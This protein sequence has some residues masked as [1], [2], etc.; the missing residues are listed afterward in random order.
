MHRNTIQIT[1]IL[2]VR[3]LFVLL[4]VYAAV[5]K[6]LDFETFKIQIGDTVLLRAYASGIA[7]SLIILQLLTVVLLLFERTRR[8]GLY[9]S[10]ILMS[11]F[12]VYILI[13][14]IFSKSIPCACS[15]IIPAMGW[16]AHLF[17]NTTLTF[18]A[19]L[20]ILLEKKQT[21]RYIDNTT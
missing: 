20:G 11:L 21:P 1:I 12:T 18:F 9:L 14:L 17:F 7:W 5:R 2:V 6:L 4:F 19:F 8:S 15:G 13:I 10:F 3:Y 16:R